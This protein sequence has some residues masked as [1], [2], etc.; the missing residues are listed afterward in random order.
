MAV[1]DA[2][3]RLREVGLH[4]LENHRQPKGGGRTLPKILGWIVVLLLIVPALQACFAVT[5]AVYHAIPISLG[6]DTVHVGE[7]VHYGGLDYTVTGVSFQH[8][9]VLVAN[10]GSEPRDIMDNGKSSGS[11]TSITLHVNGNTYTA[12]NDLRGSVFGDSGWTL[13]PGETYR[14]TLVFPHAPTMQDRD[15]VPRR[16]RRLAIR[17]HR[18]GDALTP[19]A[20]GR[21][22][23]CDF[24]RRISATLSSAVVLLF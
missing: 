24:A 15:G 5:A 6:G 9:T 18:Q 13:D 23:L 19:F 10:H 22:V 12:E 4:Q 1:L 17:S 8:V 14:A 21:L 20:D 7:P 11:M 2:A 3:V 16:Q